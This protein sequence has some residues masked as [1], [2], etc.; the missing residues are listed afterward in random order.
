M[1][2]VVFA[3]FTDDRHESSIRSL[4]TISLLKLSLFLTLMKSPSIDAFP[5]YDGSSWIALL[6]SE[7]ASA[8]CPS[9]ACTFGF[10]S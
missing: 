7:R 4:Q 3:S 6:K 9:T 8:S 1:S 5:L 2:A 10:R